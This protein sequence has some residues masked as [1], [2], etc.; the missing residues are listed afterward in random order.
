MECVGLAE[1]VG[2]DSLWLVEV[3]DVD[4]IALASS[5][6]QTT[7]KIHVATGVVNSHLRVPTLLAMSA[8]TLSNLSGGRFMLGIGSGSPQASYTIDIPADTQLTRFRET[9]QIV[10]L[11]L[12]GQKVYFHGSL[13][14]V[15]GF[16][17]G[18]RP[19]SKVTIYGA[20]MGLKMLEAAA[21]LADGVL[22]M[23]PTVEHM[24]EVR[25]TIDTVREKLRKTTPPVACHLLT[26]VSRSKKEAERVAKR[27]V[28]NYA[29]FPAYRNSFI[30]MGF[31][32]EIRTLEQSR[33][34]RVGSIWERV[35]TEMAER[36]IIYG[37]ADECVE[38][39]ADFVTAGVTY[40]IIYPCSI[41]SE[42]PGKI[43]ETIRAFAPYLK[44]RR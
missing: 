13:F 17:L 36:L 6:C 20:A 14:D 40:P 44:Q 3:S 32:D 42:F 43:K 1:S 15:N 9:L 30:R 28:A 37:S 29:A 21:E 27:T 25:R 4:T 23:L 35:P 12:S 41:P 8:A 24:K 31:A 5:I 22:V 16:K 11:C 10:K 2:F 26:A 39:V 33:L 34:D 7:K 38:R 19:T 18:I